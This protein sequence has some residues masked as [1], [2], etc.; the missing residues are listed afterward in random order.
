MILRYGDKFCLRAAADDAKDTV[1]AFT[2]PRLFANLS[3]LACKFEP[4]NILRK[5]RWRG[6]ASQ[7]LQD[8]GAINAG[9]AHAHSHAISRRRRRVASLA[10]AENF[11]ATMRFD[12]Y[13]AHDSVGV[14]IKP[15]VD[16]TVLTS[17]QTGY[18]QVMQRPGSGSV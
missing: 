9:G 4:G 17:G 1:A 7:P 8:V 18:N 11:D 2:H 12:I 6:I 16:G 13:C 3:H 14:D 15:S 5:T 10:D